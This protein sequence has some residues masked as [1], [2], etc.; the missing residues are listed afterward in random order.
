[1]Y[2]VSLPRA[3]ACL[4]HTESNLINK[5]RR[6]HPLIV[7]ERQIGAYLRRWQRLAEHHR[8]I[9][10]ILITI[11]NPELTLG[12]IVERAVEDTRRIARRQLWII[13]DGGDDHRIVCG[14]P[15]WRNGPNVGDGWEETAE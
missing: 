14:C 4:R 11:P 6:L 3:L 5:R 15:V 9:R 13:L 1:M 8:R 7:G 2:L 10:S 12:R